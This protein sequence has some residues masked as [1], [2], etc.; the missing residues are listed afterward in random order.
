MVLGP[1]V[2]PPP[3]DFSM[4]VMAVAMMIHLPLS[5]LYG[6]VLGWAVHRLGMGAALLGGAAFGLVAVYLVNFYVIAPMVFPWFTEARNWISLVSHV[7]V[8]GAVLAG[9]Y[10]A[11]RRR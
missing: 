5:M 3:A 8:F 9:V 2:L 6:L 1:G 7:V 4:S 11:M 10:V